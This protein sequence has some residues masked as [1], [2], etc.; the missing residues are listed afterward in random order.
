MISKISIFLSLISYIY[1]GEVITARKVYIV[2]TYFSILN[3]SMVYFWPV[4]L[5]NVAEAYISAKRLQ[6][7]LLKSETKGSNEPKKKSKSKKVDDSKLNG[8]AT[9][10]V[11]KNP[12]N[13]KSDENRRRNIIAAIDGAKKENP[14]AFTAEEKPIGNRIVNLD[15]EKKGIL[16]ENVTAAWDVLGEEQKHGIFDITTEIQPGLLCTVVGQVG[17]GKSTLLNVILGELEVDS[18][19][20]TVNGKISYSSQEAWLFEGSVR[21][22]IVF[23]EEFDEQRYNQVVEVCALERDFRLL[24]KGDKTIVGERGTSL[25]GGQRARKFKS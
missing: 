18:G 12:E 3:L 23:V 19:T 4:A 15:A 17:S 9:N 11:V 1:F 6:E 13:S 22:N 2:M 24:P 20:V 5:T 10:G 25:S 16:F 21:D 8:A 7:F 14:I